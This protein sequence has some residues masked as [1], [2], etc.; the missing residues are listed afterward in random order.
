MSFTPLSHTKACIFALSFYNGTSSLL[1]AHTLSCTRSDILYARSR[2]KAA[3]HTQK[4]LF[5]YMRESLVYHMSNRQDPCVH[6]TYR[7]PSQPAPGTRQ[8]TPSQIRIPAVSPVHSSHHSPLLHHQ[9]TRI[10]LIVKRTNV[11]I[12][13]YTADLCPACVQP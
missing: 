9:Y 1:E 7:L 4:S 8:P 10:G 12:N 2:R 6:Y 5:H 13:S 11:P 3:R